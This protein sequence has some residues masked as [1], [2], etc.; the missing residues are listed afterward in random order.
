MGDRLLVWRQLRAG[1]VLR[2]KQDVPC[3]LVLRCNRSTN[4]FAWTPLLGARAGVM[5]AP[6]FVATGT[7][8]EALQDGY[9]SILRG[10][11]VIFNR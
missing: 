5:F 1:D 10:D 11:E 3:A 4:E 6:D 8:D 2:N 7:W 9:G